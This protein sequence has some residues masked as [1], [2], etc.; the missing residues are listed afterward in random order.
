[1]KVTN[2]RHIVIGITGGIAAYKSL[3]L[4]RLFKTAGYDVRVV[5]THNALQFVTKLSIETLAQSTL[6]FDSFE[7]PEEYQVE[8]ISLADWADLVV[9]APATANIMGKWANGIAD[10]ALSTFLLAVT[11]PIFMAPAMNCNMYNHPAVQENMKTLQQR[12]VTFLEPDNG[13]LACGYEGKGRMM[14]PDQIFQSV[15]HFLNQNQIFWNK[16]V[17]VTAGPTYEPIDPVR[18]IG[19]HSSGLMGFE[20]AD[21]LADMGAAVTLITGPTHLSTRNQNISRINVQTANQMLDNTLREAEN[22]QLV[23]MAAAVADYTPKQIATQKIKKNEADWNIS[24]VKTVD[25]LSELGKRKPKNQ[26]L[27]GF[28][29][30][31]ENELANAT[32]KLQNK[33][34][35]L[36]VLNSMNHKDAG[37][38]KPTNQVTII[39]KEGVLLETGVKSKKEIAHEIIS[40]VHT[41]FFSN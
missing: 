7:S 14:E 29:L 26:C 3:S 22:A 5:A 9:V 18:F 20:I 19:N 41:H 8:H 6:Y 13:F 1:M 38:N 17:V 21:T 11:K 35:D 36:I 31:T 24:V 30:E 2:H 37:F 12:G 23:V 32:Q 34:A 15:T 16:K 39:S 40:T 4:I 10:D 28:A 25:I 33:N 27:V